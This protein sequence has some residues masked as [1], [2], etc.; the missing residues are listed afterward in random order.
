MVKFMCLIKVHPVLEIKVQ[1]SHCNTPVNG[2]SLSH[3]V[4]LR[5]KSIEYKCIFTLTYEVTVHTI[6]YNELVIV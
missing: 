1:L 4:H 3:E 6:G 2:E 5:F